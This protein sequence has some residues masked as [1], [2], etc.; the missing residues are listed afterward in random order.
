MGTDLNAIRTDAGL[1]EAL[2]RASSHEMTASEVQEQRISFIYGS[3]KPSAGLTREKI[4]E[5]LLEQYGLS[6]P[7]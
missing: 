3:V 7:A 2:K 5:V 6:N 4:R 1:L